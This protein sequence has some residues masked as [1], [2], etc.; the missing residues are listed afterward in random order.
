MDYLNGSSV[1]YTK[2]IGKDAVGQEVNDHFFA[3]ELF[4]ST[5]HVFDQIYVY[6]RI[7]IKKYWQNIK[8]S[9]KNIKTMEIN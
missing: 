6:F 3:D 5:I 1:L 9:L 2:K 7:R 8:Y 4:L